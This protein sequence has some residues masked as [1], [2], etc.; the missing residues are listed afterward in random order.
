MMYAKLKRR[1]ISNILRA[2]EGVRG[3]AR[4]VGGTLHPDLPREDLER[5]RRQM[6][7]CVRGRG[8]EVSTRA[9]TVALGEVYFQLS[10][11]GR[12]RFLE[13]LATEF[14]VDRPRLLEM[15]QKYQQAD[16]QAQ[17]AL[18]PALREVLKSDRIRILRS[19]NGLPEGVKFLV[20]MREDL[21][22]LLKKNPALQSLEA[23]LK[24]LL[25][26]WFDIGLLDLVQIDWHASASVLEKL[27][28]Y[29]A[30]HA[31]TSWNDLKNRLDSD[32]RCFG[33]FHNKMPGEPLIFVEV[34]LMQGIADNVQNLLD[35][36]KPPLNPQLA[37]TAVFYSISNAQKGLSGISFGNFL[38]KRV[39]DKLSQDFKNLQHFATLSPM[40][41]F[42]SWLKKTL[43]E[44]G[45]AL[46]SP[47][48][49]KAIL[50]QTG[51]SLVS[52]SLLETLASKDWH[53]K[54][55]LT[56]VLQAP[57]VRLGAEYLYA[58][59]NDKDRALD[60]VANFH[61][62]NGA[63]MHRINWLA[64]T[65]AN[66]LKQACGLMVN[67]YYDLAYIDDNHEQYMASGTVAASKA[68]KGLL[69]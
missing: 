63:R 59:K 39:V 16:V 44:K 64:D 6:Q 5:L 54:K 32:R 60:P 62:T 21:L 57:L 48:E 43:A 65:S 37:D 8:G 41:G 11:K 19:F 22:P 27:I 28:E 46:F 29:E 15:M 3:T 53:S 69:K 67:Y 23:D 1:T 45:D 18:E 13:V 56:D 7:G 52:E 20:D 24:Y 47:A 30:V 14:D 50:A 12:T 33:F 61:L 36:S 34:A 25:S 31:I 68:V 55:A 42:H 38:I 4:R 10:E 66:G 58:A 26:S 2:W 9:R 17:S 49:R 35:E 51:G 40:P